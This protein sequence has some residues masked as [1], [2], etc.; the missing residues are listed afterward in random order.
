MKGARFFS[1]NVRNGRAFD[2]NDLPGTGDVENHIKM[3]SAKAT[4]T[5]LRLLCWIFVNP[6]VC[7]E[8]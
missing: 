6:C 3:T 7:S 1:D 8:S 2:P 4:V 5:E